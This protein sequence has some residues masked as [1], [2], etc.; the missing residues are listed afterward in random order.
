MDRKG[1]RLLACFAFLQL[2]STFQAPALHPTIPS[3]SRQIASKTPKYH[4]LSPCYKIVSSIH[5]AKLP[6]DPP[7][8]LPATFLLGALLRARGPP[9]WPSHCNNAS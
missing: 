9:R 1:G 7:S 3:A 2:P 5:R 4:T 6:Q 8:A